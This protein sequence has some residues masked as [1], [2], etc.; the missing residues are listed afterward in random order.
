MRDRGNRAIFLPQPPLGA[1]RTGYQAQHGLCTGSS[2]VRV[3][4]DDACVDISREPLILGFWVGWNGMKCSPASKGVVAGYCIFLVSPRIRYLF[5]KLPRH[6]V[7]GTRG[8]EIFRPSVGKIAT[9]FFFVDRCV[10]AQ[11]HGLAFRVIVCSLFFHHTEAPLVMTPQG[12]QR[13]TKYKSR[14]A[15]L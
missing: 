10:D 8:L 13:S 9:A 5:Q 2:L 12:T 7:A 4:I 14:W 3:G 6:L 15:I 1:L 11:R